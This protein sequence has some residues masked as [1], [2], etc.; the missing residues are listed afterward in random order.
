MLKS[1]VHYF[2][3]EKGKIDFMR[4]HGS[5]AMLE[6]KG[7]NKL[8]IYL[9]GGGILSENMIMFNRSNVVWK[10]LPN[11]DTGYALTM[12]LGEVSIPIGSHS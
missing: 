11:P 12:A 8:H 4:E 10:V 5:A 9:L 1:F 7:I 2:K 6:I 3:E